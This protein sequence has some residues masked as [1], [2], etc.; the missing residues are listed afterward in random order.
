VS[1][2][3]TPPRKSSS[4]KRRVTRATRPAR[5]KVA[6]RATRAGGV[7]FN[8]VKKELRAHIAKLEK[9]LGGPEA[10]AAAADKSPYETLDEL[11]AINQRLTS[12]CQPT[13][14]IGNS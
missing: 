5:K 14:V 7:D 6:A 10:R 8:P 12:L 11:R 2:K 1:K 13:M 9:Q 4:T 3:R